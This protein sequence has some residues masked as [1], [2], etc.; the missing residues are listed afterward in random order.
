MLEIEFNPLYHYE[1]IHKNGLN[2][3]LEFA[4]EK[5]PG[6]LDRPPFEPREGKEIASWFLGEKIQLKMVTRKI[7]QLNTTDSVICGDDLFYYVA[8]EVKNA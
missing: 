3:L 8:I 5:C 4:D 1:V 2:V 7:G 6:M